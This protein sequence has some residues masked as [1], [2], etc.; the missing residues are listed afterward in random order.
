MPNIE[1]LQLSRPPKGF[2]RDHPA[3]DLIRCREWGV[4]VSLP[5]TAAL[6]PTLPAEIIR[7]IRAA[8]PLVALLNKPILAA[9]AAAPK[10]APNAAFHPD[11][12]LW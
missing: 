7:H 11:F 10:P 5:I 9:S 1:N 2:S 6:K 4:S 8:A 3:E 12:A